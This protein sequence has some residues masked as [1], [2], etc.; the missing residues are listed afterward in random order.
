[1]FPFTFRNISL[2]GVVTPV[3]YT[4]CSSLDLHTPWCPTE[5]ELDG[6]T[7]KEWGKNKKKKKRSIYVGL[8]SFNLI[9]YISR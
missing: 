9:D 3:N 2:N 5:F 4:K 7:I 1:M 6:V 8:G